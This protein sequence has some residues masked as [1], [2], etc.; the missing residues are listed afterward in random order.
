MEILRKHHTRKHHESTTPRFPAFRVGNGNRDE[1]R[2]RAEMD[3][4]RAHSGR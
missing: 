2:M 1:A 3:A 4:I